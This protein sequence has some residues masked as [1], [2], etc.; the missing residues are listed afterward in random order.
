MKY[1]SEEYRKFR[2][3]VRDA[4]KLIDPA[5]ADMM[6]HSVSILDP[7]GVLDPD[8]EREDCIGREYFVW[9]PNSDIWVELSDLPK[10]ILEKVFQLQEAGYYKKARRAERLA[11]RVHKLE[12]QLQTAGQLLELLGGETANSDLADQARQLGT[13]LTEFASGFC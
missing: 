12:A 2:Q 13:D 11:Q 9:A 8:P 1:D 7:Y 4:G 6:F 3:E 10:E 5:A